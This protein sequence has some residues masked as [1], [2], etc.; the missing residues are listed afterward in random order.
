VAVEI[1]WDTPFMHILVS[2]PAFHLL[3]GTDEE[4]KACAFLGRNR[5]DMG[6]FLPDKKRNIFPTGEVHGRILPCHSQP[7]C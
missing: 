1:L 5:F 7:G 3:F 2:L 4:G 6:E